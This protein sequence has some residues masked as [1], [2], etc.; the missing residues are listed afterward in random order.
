[1][2]FTTNKQL[3]SLKFWRLRLIAIGLMAGLAGCASSPTG[4]LPENTA[5]KSWYYC[6]PANQ[7]IR[8]RTWDCGGARRT[9]VSFV[10]QINAQPPHQTSRRAPTQSS[11]APPEHASIATPNR[12]TITTINQAPAHQAP[13]QPTKTVSTAPT[14]AM[15]TTAT[16]Q[17]PSTEQSIW[18]VQLAAFQNR[19][20][21]ERFLVDHDQISNLKIKETYVA[22]AQ[23][24]RVVAYSGASRNEA[25][26]IANDIKQ[27]HPA[28]T[29]W[30]RSLKP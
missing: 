9:P 28:I 27:Q 10:S 24:Y 16:T 6:D 23:W 7:N 18:L 25:T 22:G 29:P 2:G 4:D 19:A 14:K 30:V 12:Q 15:V 3:L 8:S 26:A 17:R 20:K 21:A 11:I 5:E 1:M 13:K